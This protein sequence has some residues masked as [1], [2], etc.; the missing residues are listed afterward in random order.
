MNY[1]NEFDL[2]QKIMGIDNLNI[3]SYIDFDYFIPKLDGI[4]KYYCFLHN[5]FLINKSI[6]LLKVLKKGIKLILDF[7]DK[8]IKIDDLKKIMSPIT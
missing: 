2:L 3:L 4:I 1:D 8:I 7:L 6:Y 5:E